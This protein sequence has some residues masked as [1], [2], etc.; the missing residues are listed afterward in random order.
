[1]LC[2]YITTVIVLLIAKVFGLSVRPECDA[3][4][5]SC[6]C[7]S[8]ASRHNAALRQWR[9]REERCRPKGFP[10]AGAGLASRSCGMGVRGARGASVILLCM[11]FWWVLQAT[12]PTS[13]D[14]KS[15]SS[16][17]WGGFP[18]ASWQV[19]LVPQSVFQK[20]QPL[21]FQAPLLEKLYCLSRGQFPAWLSPQQTSPSSRP[22]AHPLQQDPNLR[23]V[24]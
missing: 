13:S 2:V 18:E 17:W 11:T 3:G 9:A 1:M 24:C 16:G 20:I 10:V 23:L 4:T 14:F 22:S 6:K 8:F 19:P 5:E 7:P 15:T 21:S 12:Y